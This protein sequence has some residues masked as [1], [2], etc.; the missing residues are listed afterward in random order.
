MNDY[1]MCPSEII[2]EDKW[3]CDRPYFNYIEVMVGATGT[4][5]I[6]RISMT[7]SHQDLVSSLA[8]IFNVNASSFKLCDCR[9]LPWTYPTSLKDT[10]M[11]VVTNLTKRR[12]AID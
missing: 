8:T 4:S 9:G 11:V 1:D 7:A 10:M 12:Y 5:F 3:T 2:V 6:Y